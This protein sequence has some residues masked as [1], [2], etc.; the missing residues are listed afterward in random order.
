LEYSTGGRD[1]SNKATRYFGRCSEWE[2]G[3]SM[4]ANPTIR[5]PGLM[6]RFLDTIFGY[7]PKPVVISDKPKPAPTIVKEEAKEIIAAKKKPEKPAGSESKH[8]KTTK[9]P[10]L[11]DLNECCREFLK[12]I[13]KEMTLAAT[14]NAFKDHLKRIGKDEMTMKQFAVICGYPKKKSLLKIFESDLNEFIEVRK[15]G[16]KTILLPLKYPIWHELN[17]SSKGIKLPREPKT[18]Y[19]IYLLLIPI[20]KSGSSQGELLIEFSNFNS[21]TQSRRK[22]ILSQI[23][24]ALF[25]KGEESEFWHFPNLSYEELNQKLETSVKEGNG[26]K[27]PD[28]GKGFNWAVT[29]YFRNV[30]LHLDDEEE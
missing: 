9:S 26:W 17:N 12:V 23:K 20:I 28:R 15:E 13:T 1:Y 11:N 14:G 22:R 10:S 29:E 18:M 4:R 25:H 3:D 5:K 21:L 8:V 24:R 30:R 6:T 19:E 7:E 16:T 27:I 2:I